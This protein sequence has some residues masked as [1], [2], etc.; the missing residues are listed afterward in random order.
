MFRF[1]AIKPARRKQKK[2]KV[3]FEMNGVVEDSSRGRRSGATRGHSEKHREGVSD[4][5]SASG[6]RASQLFPTSIASAGGL[7]RH[8]LPNRTTVFTFLVVT[9]GTIASMLFLAIGISGAVREQQIQFD[10]RAEE[11]M[12]EIQAA[13]ADYE[14]AGLWLHQ[15]CR[16]G[17][18]TREEFRNVYENMV[19]GGLEVKVC[20]G[21]ELDHFFKV[22]GTN[23]FFP[24]SLP[25]N[26]ALH[27]SPMLPERSA[28]V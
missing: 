23:H 8:I 10:L 4:S 11:L 21:Q 16:S 9:I 20:V 26:R 24:Y 5:G 25:L 28:K 17:Q 19:H 6:S 14:T 1:S 22:R 27:G 2:S 13:F 7:N 3:S 18:I 12:I 15:S